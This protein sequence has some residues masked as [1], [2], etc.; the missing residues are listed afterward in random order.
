M[1]SLQEG[2][3]NDGRRTNNNRQNITQKTNDRATRTPLKTGAAPE[4]EAVPA[5]Q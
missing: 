4:E 3:I 5:P 1:N 2:E